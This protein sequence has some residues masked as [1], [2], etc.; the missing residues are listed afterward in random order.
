MEILGARPAWSKTSSERLQVLDAVETELAR[1]KTVRLH[2]MASVDDSGDAADLGAHDTVE[3]LSLRHNRH[4]RD[5]RRD[6]TLAKALPKYPAVSAALPDPAADLGSDLDDHVASDA[7]PDADLESDLAAA[8]DAAAD[9]AADPDPDADADADGAV[10]PDFDADGAV[11]S[12]AGVRGR[13]VIRPAQAQVIVSALEKLPDTV[14]VE[15][16]EVAEQ[17]LVKLA[18]HL[19]PVELRK[20]AKHVCDLL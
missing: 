5:V 1:L 16:I 19:N 17:E 4:P 12:D 20:A 15:D 6:L 8:P 3:L 9:D 11:D 18:A 14:P 13:V 10:D 7:D 2:Y